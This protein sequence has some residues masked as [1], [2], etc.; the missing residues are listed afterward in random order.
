MGPPLVVLLHGSRLAS[1]QWGP[2]R[3]IL[4]PSLEVLTP[5][6][7]GHGSRAGD[8]FTLAA[9][10]AVLEALI[11]ADDTDPARPVI[12][13]GHSLGGYVAMTYAERHP[14]R[15]AAL[16]LADCAAEP[17]GIGAA[18]Y[19]RLVALT[20]RLGAERMT[21]IND[22][23]LRRLYPP[24]RVEAVIAGGYYFEHTRA[25][26]FEVMA[27]CGSHQLRAVSAPI[28]VVNGRFDQFRVGS[29]RFCR[30]LQRYEVRV[31]PGA[32]HLSCLDQPARFAAEITRVVDLV[33]RRA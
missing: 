31:I 11:D 1:A 30:G 6:L 14:H 25:A 13:V 17:R 33:A 3:A 12:L 18:A 20:D 8:E 9:S 15:L 24:E 21:R 22:R 19:R 26:W 7:P 16:V 29:A 2:V 5:D 27:S 10:V 4:D 32:G 23:V 28:V